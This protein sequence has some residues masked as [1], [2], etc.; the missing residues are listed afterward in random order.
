MK[1]QVL[2]TKDG[3]NIPV[4]TWTDPTSIAATLT[5]VISTINAVLILTHTGYSLPPLATALVPA[6]SFLVAGGVMAV[7]VI[8]HYKVTVALVARQ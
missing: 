5:A 1:R 6:I 7:N 2:T 4:P 3:I 8:R